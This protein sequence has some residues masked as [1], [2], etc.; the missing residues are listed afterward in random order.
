MST[1]SFPENL[2]R[3][4]ESGA[5]LARTPA[6]FLAPSGKLW[7]I[8]R[9][10][11]RF[12]A[13]DK[14]VS[15]F[16]FEWNT[17]P[18]TQ[19]DSSNDAQARSEQVLHEKTGLSEEDVRGE[20]VLDAGVGAGRFSE[21][22]ARWGARVVGVDLSF[23]VEAARDNLSRFPHVQIAQADIFELPFA[24]ETFDLI[25]SIGVLHHTPD[26]ER[27]FQALV[28]LLKPGGRICIWVY[29]DA[30]DY[31]RRDVWIPFTRNVPSRLFYRFCRRL[32]G[33]ARRH[34]RHPLIRYLGGVFPIS[35]QGYGLEN[36]VLDTFDG[37]SPYFHG[38]HAPAE[39]E[40]W[41]REAGLGEIEGQPGWPTAVRGTKPP[42][43]AA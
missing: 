24:P 35:D 23:A 20:L 10:V 27:A 12:V 32:V 13:S 15:S 29:P 40:G 33:L 34:P 5:E 19:L 22:L 30:G 7:P 28:R 6:G 38:T 37:Y 9:G 18:Q 3:C 8:E 42:A 14:Y 21:V 26:T 16:S 25:V 31:A 41:F 4:P 36:D 43:G 11:P 1:E 39:V 17:H 2:F